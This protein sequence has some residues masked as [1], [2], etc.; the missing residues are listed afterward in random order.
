MSTFNIRLRSALGELFDQLWQGT[1]GAAHVAGP[2]QLPGGLT[3]NV[4]FDL[5]ST[6]Q[7]ISYATG[8]KWLA[9]SYRLLPGAT[10]VANQYA[11]LVLNAASDADA[12]GKLATVG[13]YILVAQG[14]DLLIPA[15]ASDLIKRVDFMTAAAVGAEKTTLRFLAGV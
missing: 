6:R 8:A 12:D 5:T 11:K 1:N 13:M 10:A 15:P 4:V 7:Q 14:D 2:D 3:P 9:I